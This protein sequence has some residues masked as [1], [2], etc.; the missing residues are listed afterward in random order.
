MFSLSYSCGEGSQKA[1][2]LKKNTIK[3]SKNYKL[4][5]GLKYQLKISLQTKSK[6]MS[7]GNLL[8]ICRFFWGDAKGE[9]EG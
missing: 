7:A 6:V 4:G 1:F 8:Q 5:K 2:L 9:N 3:D